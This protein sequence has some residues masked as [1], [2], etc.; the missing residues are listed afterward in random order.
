[1]KLEWKQG[2]KATIHVEYIPLNDEKK[3][4]DFIFKEDS[5]FFEEHQLLELNN[6]E[7]SALTKIKSRISKFYASDSEKGIQAQF[8]TNTGG[9]IDSEFSYGDSRKEQMRIDLI[10]VDTNSEKILAVELKT[11]Q[12][13]RL[14]NDEIYNQ[15]KFYNEFLTKHEDDL[16]NYYN[17]LFLIKKKLGILP[18]RLVDLKSLEKY[19][20]IAKPLLLLGDCQ[21]DWIDKNSQTI[22]DRVHEVACGVYYF[23]KPEYDCD[24]IP[25]SKRNRHIFNH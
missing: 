16:K 23:G 18:A 5:V 8:I 15:L 19:E 7:K 4:S 25:Q 22:D 2:Y 14:Y 3:Y 6:F 10:W 20:V 11:V 12:D 21:Q 9:F 13:A 1:M 17:I 24:L